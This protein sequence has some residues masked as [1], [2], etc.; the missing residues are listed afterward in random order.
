MTYVS[1]FLL[2]VPKK[3]KSE[4]IEMVKL[5][6]QLFKE[7]GA[8]DL[9]ENWEKDV[10]EGKITS[11]PMAVKK[12]PYEDVVFSWISWPDKETAEACWA[13][14]DTDERWEP[15]KAAPFDTKRMIIGG[16]EPIFKS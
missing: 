12:E 14:F 15:I 5:S 7:Y 1:G 11:F 3:N 10:L 9:Q 16:F 2:A 4:Y 8:I 13:S 6:W